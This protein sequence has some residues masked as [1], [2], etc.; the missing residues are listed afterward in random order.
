MSNVAP[1]TVAYGDGISPEIMNASLHIMKEAGARIEI[2]VVEISEKLHLSGVL[3]QG[4]E[5]VKTVTLRTFDGK[6]G[7]TLAQ[8]Q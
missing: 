4:D 2:D 5:V 3:G 8:G 6:A 1:I 7:C